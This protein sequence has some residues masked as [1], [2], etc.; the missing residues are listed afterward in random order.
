MNISIREIE[1][2]T[3]MTVDTSILQESVPLFENRL[4]ELIERGRVWIV[5]DLSMA[6]YLSSMGVALL[7][8]MKKE[9]TAH[10]GD[11]TIANANQL[12]QN[13]LDYTLVNRKVSVVDTLENAI[14]E[15]KRKKET[16]SEE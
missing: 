15:L 8:K 4:M 10:G 2:I 7:V 12:I 3:V 16:P 11:C 1:D 6:S 5:L 14:D 13:L 9:L